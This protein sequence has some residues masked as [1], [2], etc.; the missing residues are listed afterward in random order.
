VVEGAGSVGAAAAEAW[1]RGGWRVVEGA[2][3]EGAAVEGA[4]GVGAAVVE[5]RR[6]GG[7]TAA[8]GRGAA[9]EGVVASDEGAAMSEGAAGGRGRGRGGQGRGG[10]ERGGESRLEGGGGNRQI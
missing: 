4:G 5:A 2:A 8:E 7:C 9:G 6:R 10:V 3:A 1:Q